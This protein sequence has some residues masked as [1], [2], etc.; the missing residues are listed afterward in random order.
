MKRRQE[1]R[2]VAETLR[3][4][5]RPRRLDSHK[6]VSEIPGAVHQ[7]KDPEL[8]EY[9]YREVEKM[10]SKPYPP[11]EGLK[12]VMEVYDSHE[13]RKY[14]LEHFYD[15]SFVRELDESGYIDSLYR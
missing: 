11:Y 13:M 15:D 5:P 10:P 1:S 12:K 7:L 4:R 2:F 14:T 6:G 8:L 9:F 3:Y